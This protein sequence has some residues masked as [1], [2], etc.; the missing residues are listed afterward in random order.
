[1][2]KILLIAVLIVVPALAAA[3]DLEQLARRGYAVVAE[4]RTEGSFDGCHLDKRIAL[5]NK[6]VLV[7]TA[8][9]FGMAF[10]PEVLILKHPGR[11]EVKVLVDGREQP[12]RQQARDE[13]C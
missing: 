4:T 8:S 10:R 12:V 5:E 9:S 11:P 1:V 6:Q 7:C 13:G 2:T 3:S